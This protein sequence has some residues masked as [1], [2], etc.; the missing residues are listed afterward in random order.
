VYWNG[1]AL[2]D[3]TTLE[4]NLKAAAGQAVQPEL[5]LRPD[6]E[7]RYQIVAGVMASSQRLGLT[8]IGIVG[9]E[10]FIE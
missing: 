3:R 10:Q 4:D 6:K 2:P 1:A 8:K 9:S 7:V 5:H